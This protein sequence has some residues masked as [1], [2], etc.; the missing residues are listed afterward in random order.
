MGGPVIGPTDKTVWRRVDVPGDGRE[1]RRRA[2]ALRGV[3]AGRRSVVG[4]A[5][6]MLAPRR[7]SL[8]YSPVFI[9]HTPFVT[10]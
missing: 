6:R 5:P 9:V 4:G 1:R 3:A 2:K 8:D 10:A 7:L